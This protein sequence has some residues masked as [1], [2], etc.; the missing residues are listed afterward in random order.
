VGESKEPLSK[1]QT[2]EAATRRQQ[3]ISVSSA[4]SSDE[5]STDDED[6]DD[7]LHFKINIGIGV[8][9]QWHASYIDEKTANK[10]LLI[11]LDKCDWKNGSKE[12]FIRVME[13]ADEVLNCARVYLRATRPS[14]AAEQQKMLKTFMFLGFRVVPPSVVASILPDQ[15]DSLLFVT[16]L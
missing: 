8:N 4:Y 16:E 13:C 15:P 5:V 3:S 2:V 14:D 1:Q 11:D 6:D 7:D 12:A 10:G 9:R